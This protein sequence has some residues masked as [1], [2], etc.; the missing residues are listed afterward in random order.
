MVDPSAL[1]ADPQWLAHRFVE[2]GDAFRFAR[3]ERERHDAVP[4]LVDSYLGP[5]D[6]GGDVPTARCL[7][8][9]EAPPLHFLF[10]SAFCGSTMLTRA[11]DVPG[12]AMGLSEPVVLNDVVGFRR[13]GAAPPAVARAA[14][15]ATRLLGRPFGAGEA[16]VVKPSNLINPLAGLLLALRPRSRAV[17]LHAPLETFLISV[18]HK[19]MHCRIWVR[20]LLE[21]YLR[22]GALAGMGFEAENFFRQSDLQVAAV[23]WLAQMRIFERLGERIGPQRLVS[24]DADLMLADPAE[25][26]ARAAEHYGLAMRRE[27]AEALAGGPAFTRHSKSG[28]AYTPEKRAADYARVREAHGDEIGMVAEWARAVAGTAGIPLTARWPLLVQS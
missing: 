3:V 20:E 11:F 6:I 9:P 16:A 27:Q 21:G 12:L 25:A 15:A 8:L 24:L 26:I 17:F 14:D 2:E 7:E 5:L 28:G 1:L 4:F 18:A 23:G 10:H 13:R 22:D 19:G